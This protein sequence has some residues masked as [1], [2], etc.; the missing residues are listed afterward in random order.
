MIRFNFVC[1]SYGSSLRPFLIASHIGFLKC[2]DWK[3]VWSNLGIYHLRRAF[4]DRP[5]YR[6]WFFSFCKWSFN[7]HRREFSRADTYVWERD[8]ANLLSEAELL[9][10]SKW[11]T[12]A[13]HYLVHIPR[14]VFFKLW[15][16]LSLSFSLYLSISLDLSLSLSLESFA[17]SWTDEL[18]KR[19]LG[20]PHSQVGDLYVSRKSSFQAQLKRAHK[21][22]FLVG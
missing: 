9:Y 2:H 13:T 15:I 8:I 12:G 3:L 6:Q 4:L 11:C 7:V 10:P 14:S 19:E 17:D 1:R 18:K 16:F 20:R 22:L 21:L 5:R